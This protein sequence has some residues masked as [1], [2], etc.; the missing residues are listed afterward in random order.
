MAIL[1][2]FIETLEYRMHRHHVYEKI[3]GY[4]WIYVIW[5]R[6]GRDKK[7]RGQM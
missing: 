5:L 7:A 3:I 6:K 4:I 2:A 1:N